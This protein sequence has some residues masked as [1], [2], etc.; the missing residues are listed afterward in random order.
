LEVIRLIPD[1]AELKDKAD[2]LGY[3]LVRYDE[4]EKKSDEVL[5]ERYLL[6]FEKRKE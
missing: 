1:M 4:F 5:K 3:R 2:E 6:V